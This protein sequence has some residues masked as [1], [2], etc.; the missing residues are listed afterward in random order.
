VASSKTRQRKLARA[1]VERQQVR[2]AAKARRTRQVQA[3][4]AAGVVAVLAIV[5]G[6][7]A[8]G[9]FSSKPAPTVTE[10]CAWN[11]P[12]NASG[13]DDVG[14]PPTSGEPRTGSEPMTLTT[15]QG[16]IQVSLDLAKAPCAASSL[17]YLAGKNFFNNSTCRHLS[18]SGSYLVCGY[19]SDATKTGPAY[20]FA[21][22]N[23]P[24]PST[25][26][27]S[28][29]APPTGSASATPSP[30]ASATPSASGSAAA[31]AAPSASASATAT[32]P[33]G[34]VAMF[35]N[36]PDANGSQF[37]IVYK[38]SV[39]PANYSRIGTVTSG[40]D[41]V[42]KIAAGGAVDSSGAS[43]SDGT[44]KIAV[45]VQSLT[46]GT[47]PSASANTQPSASTSTSA[48]PTGAANS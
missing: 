17:H 38:D 43:T 1:K 10:T 42:N 34:T 15:D 6:L 16:T 40:L 33:A 25:A 22:E 4:A 12:A 45:T 36:G 39:L 19:P 14:K 29:S 13:L 41:V 23:L 35:N 47:E 48:S 30:S 18:T 8:G 2:R 28:V 46:V 3:T 5:I 9:V 27:P 24:A 31:S 21:D 11:T 37:F 44:P 26:S 32:Y 7:W 20:T